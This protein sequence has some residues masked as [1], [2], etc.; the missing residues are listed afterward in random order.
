MFKKKKS[1]WQ[2][3]NVSFKCDDAYMYAN[4]N[5]SFTKELAFVFTHAMEFVGTVCVFAEMEMFFS[6]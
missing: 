2:G 4:K 3:I 5:K 1:L 6:I